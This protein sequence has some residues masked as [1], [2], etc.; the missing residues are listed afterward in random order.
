VH[1][2]PGSATMD[3]PRIY[4]TNAIPEDINCDGIV[5]VKDE[6]L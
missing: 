1:V 4:Q 3:M 6:V 5:N 2:N